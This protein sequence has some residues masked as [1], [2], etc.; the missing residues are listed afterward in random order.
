MTFIP[1]PIQPVVGRPPVG[2]PEVPTLVFE[3][4]G[5]P[6]GVIAASLGAIMTGA[7]PVGVPPTPVTV[8]S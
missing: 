2:V 3:A 4:M 8:F 6:A 1:M 5:P 7:P